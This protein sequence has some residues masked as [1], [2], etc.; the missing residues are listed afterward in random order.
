MP[1]KPHVRARGANG[2]VEQQA[3]ALGVTALD[4]ELQGFKFVE[5]VLAPRLAPKPPRGPTSSPRDRG[6]QQDVRA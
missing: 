3:Q 6:A 5:F 4:D 1:A 2:M